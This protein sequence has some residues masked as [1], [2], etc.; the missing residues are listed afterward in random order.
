MSDSVTVR[1]VSYWRHSSDAEAQL[2]NRLERGHSTAIIP[3]PLYGQG[4]R[5]KQGT[6]TLIWFLLTYS[7]DQVETNR[8]GD[9]DGRNEYQY[10]R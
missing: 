8:R 6:N 3:D 5:S 10:R 9:S 2:I 4:P 1:N 7:N